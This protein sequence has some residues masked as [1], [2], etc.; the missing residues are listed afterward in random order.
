MK[1]RN[2]TQTKTFRY[3]GFACRELVA[4]DAGEPG[5]I[6]TRVIWA[7]TRV[8]VLVAGGENL[9]ANSPKLIAFLDSLRIE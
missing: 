6:I 4:R 5:T 9:P 3:Q 2:S 1:D 8:F 7:N